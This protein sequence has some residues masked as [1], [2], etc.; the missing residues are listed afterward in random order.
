MSTGTSFTTEQRVKGGQKAAMTRAASGVMMK[1]LAR[2]A[3]TNKRGAELM[4]EALEG[5]RPGSDESWARGI[6]QTMLKRAMAGDIK[7]I[8][9]LFAYAYGKPAMAASD[10]EAARPIMQLVNNQL[11]MHSGPPSEVPT[12]TIAP[13]SALPRAEAATSPATS[14]PLVID[15]PSVAPPASCVPN[16]SSR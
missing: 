6:I 9:L 12:I 8:T 15:G 1:E 13:P 10:R 7:T 14:E 16:D 11:N 4:I 3:E 2:A 5:L